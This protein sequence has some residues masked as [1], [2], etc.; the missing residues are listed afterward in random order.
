[1]NLI[2]A[3][4]GTGGHIFPA[5]AVALEGKKAGMDVSFWVGGAKLPFDRFQGPLDA[6]DI[7]IIRFPSGRNPVALVKGAM[8]A[9]YPIMDMAATDRTVVV[10]AGSYAV[11][12]VLASSVLLGVPI[13]LLE[14]NVVPGR[15]VRFFSRFARCVFSEFPSARRKFVHAGNPIRPMKVVDKTSARKL[16]FLPTDRPIILV[17]GGSLASLKLAQT[18]VQAASTLKDAHFVIQTGGKIPHDGPENITFIDFISDIWLY[19]SAADILLARAGGGTIAEAALFRLPSIFV[20]YPFASD[21][22]QFHNAKFVERLGGAVVISERELT[23]EKLADAIRNLLQNPQKL[24]EM[25]RKI[26]EFARP[27]AA[28]RVINNI[29]NSVR[30]G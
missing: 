25:S 6:N 17:I 15:V 10:G 16:L 1:M 14:Q 3:S 9:A 5:V 21:N 24:S 27:N 26:G 30:C 2:V 18:A 11:A 7:P 19:Y 13:Y 29:L 23:A 28:K 4:G 12:P 22:H 8:T 20:P